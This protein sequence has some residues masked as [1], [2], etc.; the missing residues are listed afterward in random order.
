[1]NAIRA[2]LACSLVSLLA[3]CGGGGGGDAGSTDTGTATPITT[4]NSYPTARPSTGDWYAYL[5]T[6]QPTLPAGAGPK[7]RGITHY[8]KSV[9]ADGSLQRV[10]WA[11]DLLLSTWRFD[12][13]GAIVSS[14]SLGRC[15]YSSGYRETPPGGTGAGA[16]FTAS[17]VRTCGS[18]TGTPTVVN[19]T[20]AGKAEGLE[21]RT[22]DLG[23]HDTFKRSQTVTMVAAASG[24]T[25][26][27]SET[28]WDDVRTGTVVE[29]SATVTVTAKGATAPKS[30]ES[31]HLRLVAYGR[32]GQPAV[33]PA[34]RRFAGGW[35]VKFSG[36]DFGTCDNVRVSFAG[37][38]SGVCR[39]GSIPQFVS[40]NIAG[41]GSVTAGVSNGA[42]LTGQ[43][44][45]PMSVTGTWRLGNASGTWT[46][47]PL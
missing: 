9:E 31:R 5:E 30:S 46:A 39:L 19:L 24:D 40:G 13:S 7:E 22:T 45:S 43:F 33:G 25:T 18:A 26:V 16:T 34:V 14:E 2:G 35:T 42:E 20:V 3:A 37:A 29:C 17:A 11:T 28:C 12:A 15:D 4:G 6:T 41:D 27:R 1:M 32:S 10:Q 23:L 38:I 36:A 8:Y 47:S 44:S 21:R